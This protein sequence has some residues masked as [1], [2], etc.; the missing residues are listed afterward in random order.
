MSCGSSDDDN[1]GSP[2]ADEKHITMIEY[3]A[4]QKTSFY[5]FSY[6][7]NGMISGIKSTHA[8]PNVF[9]YTYAPDMIN[10]KLYNYYDYSLLNNRVVSAQDN[11][12]DSYGYS[13][14]N[15][16]NLVSSSWGTRK[17]DFIWSNGNITKI[18]RSPSSLEGEINIVYTNMRWPKNYFLFFLHGETLDGILYGH[19][20]DIQW[21]LMSEGY[22][23]N[24][25]RNLPKSINGIEYEYVMEDGYPVSVKLGDKEAKITWN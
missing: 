4:E 6:N 2:S 3:R 11:Y 18:K 24:R 17:Y 22:F 16:N 23:G 8:T 25:L 7:T 14:D 13:Y 5:Y 12:G 10:I 1:T 19:L 21:V 15:D 9:T 20:W